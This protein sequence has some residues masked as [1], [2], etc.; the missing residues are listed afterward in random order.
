MNPCLQ[1]LRET[2]AGTSRD[3]CGS[4][5][6]TSRLEE[7]AALWFHFLDLHRLHCSG[8]P[9]GSHSLPHSSQCATFRVTQLIVTL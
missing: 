7:L 1:V 6:G 5:K 9:S 8:S 3:S 4:A 2:G